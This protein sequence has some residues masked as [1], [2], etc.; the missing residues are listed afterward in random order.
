MNKKNIS[1]KKF[2]ETYEKNI[3]EYR[4]E[5]YKNIVRSTSSNNAS[6]IYLI[7]YLIP[8][9]LSILIIFLGNFSIISHVIGLLSI[10]ITNIILKI[11]S[12]ILNLDSKSNYLNEIRKL[13]FLSVEDYEKKLK[14]YVTGPGGYY[15]YL[16]KDIMDKYN[17]NEKTRKISGIHGELYYIWTNAN[18][19]KI[20]LLNS[21]TSD[22]PEIISIRFVNIRYFRID[23]TKKMI[24]L[25]TDMEDFYF[26]LDALDTLNEFIKEKRF[27]N[28]KEFTPENHI[29]DFEL[30][31]HNIKNEIDKEGKSND[32]D[33]T[34][35]LSK[36]VI[37]IIAVA[38]IIF[39]KN[40]S[41]KFT[42]F[43]ILA[44]I[45]TFIT[46][47]NATKEI[48]SYKKRSYKKDDDYI[49]IIN[50]NPECIER[51]DELKFALGIKPEYDRVYT[52]EGACYLTWVAN[53]YFHVFLN[54][55]YF[56]VVY[57]AVK[58]SDVLYFKREGGEC[59]VKLKDKTL[60]FTKDAEKIFAKILP[61]K[62]Y[63][64]IKGIQSR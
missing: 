43:F 56:N 34:I 64:W 15:E 39:L 2:V 8:I 36:I 1:H 16:L 18:Q 38:V 58:V 55:I 26:T 61:N 29:N 42:W 40:A 13:G 46:F 41:N 10:I 33:L 22:K 57:M 4:Q 30:Y 51:F 52:K 59:I 37:C 25:K 60:S 17:I 53:G 21:R 3:K 48:T 54:L 50:T 32:S 63:E 9:I 27:E 31:M 6:M 47:A 5:Y 12:S 28:I 49:K 20:L 14:K 24:V 45:I 11:M 23:Y 35:E 44:D 19:D 62:D 7:F